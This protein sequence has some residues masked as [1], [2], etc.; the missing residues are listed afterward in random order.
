MVIKVVKAFTMQTL[1]AL[2]EGLI[3]KRLLGVKGKGEGKGESQ[4]IG[5]SGGSMSHLFTLEVTLES[6]KK[7][8]VIRDGEPTERPWFRQ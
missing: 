7:E 2:V 6:I 1:R 3:I 4:Y 5:K 8:L